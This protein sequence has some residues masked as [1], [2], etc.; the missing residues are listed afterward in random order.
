[1]MLS[2]CILFLCGFF[3]S[4]SLAADSHDRGINDIGTIHSDSDDFDQFDQFDEFQA[5][6]RP[7][8]C[9]PLRVYNR[10]MTQVNDKLY[11]W[12]MKPVANGYSKVAPEPIRL[13]INRFF[14]NLFFPARGVNNLLQ[15]KF[16]QSGVEVAR[17]GINTTLGFFGFFDPAKLCWNLNSHSEDFGQTM[18]RYGLG[19]GFHIV[20]PF[21][22]PSNL[23]DGCGRFA[24]GFLNPVNYLNYVPSLAVTA[25]DK[26]NYA[27]LHLGEYESVRKD[28]LDLYLFLKNA[29]ET[30]RKKQIED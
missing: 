3:S 21:F 16:K 22:G 15:L 28:A 23:R 14:N 4:S 19:P 13:S 29:Y 25:E 24:D 1:M 17:F 10:F 9:D 18:G 2:I 5:E 27:S 30:N 11:F 7:E 8:K 6:S 12:V 20:L 26:V